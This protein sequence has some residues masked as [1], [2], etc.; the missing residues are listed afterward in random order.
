MLV[1]CVVYNG[2]LFL[3]LIEVSVDSENVFL[4][5]DDKIGVL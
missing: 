3:L 5:I 2:L 1:V 4:W